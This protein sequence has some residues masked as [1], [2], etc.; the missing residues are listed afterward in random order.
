MMLLNPK[1]LDPQQ[2]DSR[3]AEVMASTIDFFEKK[4]K[5]RLLEEAHQ[6]VW[7]DDFL[8]FI[9]NE[10]IFATLLTPPDYGD[11]DSR[12]DTCRNVP[13]NEILAFYGLP[14]WYAWQ[15]SILGLGPIWMSENEEAKRAP[16]SFWRTER[17]SPSA[18]PSRQHGADIYSTEMALTPQPDGSYRANGEKYYIG[19]G[20]EARDGFHLREDGR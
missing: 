19:N 2:L 8:D 18:S 17:S 14:Y 15:V 4:G 1:R 13:F 5:K 7:Y 3:S 6:G 9:K 10:K 16:R 20:N 12:W 11:A